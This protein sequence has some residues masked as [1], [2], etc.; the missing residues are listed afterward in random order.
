MLK[1]LYRGSGMVAAAIAAVMAMQASDAQAQISPGTIAQYC[2]NRGITTDGTIGGPLDVNQCTAWWGCIGDYGQDEDAFCTDLARSHFTQAA[3]GPIS[4][5]T[6]QTTVF[7]E[8]DEAIF[9]INRDGNLVQ[10]ESP[11]GYEHNA[12]G[13]VLDGYILVWDDGLGQ[14]KAFDIGEP[15]SGGVVA[16]LQCDQEDL[17]PGGTKYCQGWGDPAYTPGANF[18]ERFS[19]DGEVK[20]TMTFS[21]DCEQRKLRVL[22][23]VENNGCA[24]CPTG[25]LADLCFARQTDFDV[26]DGG[27]LGW[28]DFKNNHAA[29]DDSYIAWNDK[30]DAPADRDAHSVHL[31]TLTPDS[32]SRLIE[33]KVVDFVTDTSCPVVPPTEVGIDNPRIDF[34]DAGR[35]EVTKASLAAREQMSVEFEY[36]RD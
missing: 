6:N 5:P 8:F 28:G 21:P 7:C 24:T 12:N 19:L 4:P 16:D 3:E 13:I 27:S 20:F 23:V 29:S 30:G 25:G 10:F 2:K 17:S 34:D 18:V 9:R 31:S 36:K 22:N 35:L 1:R 14:N 26:D 11:L 15:V 33:A 32:A